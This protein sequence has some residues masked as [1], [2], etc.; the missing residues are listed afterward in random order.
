MRER[1]RMTY[2]GHRAG[3]GLFGGHLDVQQRAV[4]L[5][6]LK[7]QLVETTHAGQQHAIGKLVHVLAGLENDSR[8]GRASRVFFFF[9]CMGGHTSRLAGL[10]GLAGMAVTVGTAGTGATFVCLPV[11]W[12]CGGRQRQNDA[13]GQILKVDDGLGFLASCLRLA[14]WRISE[15]EIGR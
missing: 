1:E 8:V 5:C 3:V 2:H 13:L 15:S 14:S 4:L 12:A 7:V 11:R 6:M 10:A 9:T